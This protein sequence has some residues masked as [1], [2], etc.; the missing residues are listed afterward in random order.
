MLSIPDALSFHRATRVTYMNAARRAHFNLWQGIPSGYPMPAYLYPGT[1]ILLVNRAV[2]TH[3]AMQCFIRHARA[4][5]RKLVQV[6]RLQRM[7][8]GP[9]NWDEYKNV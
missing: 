7:I 6:K 5:N 9:N 3:S 1:E 8:S 4:A 2:S